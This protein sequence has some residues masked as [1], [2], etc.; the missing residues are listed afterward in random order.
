MADR[1]IYCADCGCYLGVIRD[2]K[3]KK[4][5][6]T[7][8][9]DCHLPAEPEFPKRNSPGDGTV[10]YLQNLFGMNKGRH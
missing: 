8:C 6:V 2:A 9:A 5:L 7:L 10:E 4:G 3:L 1:D